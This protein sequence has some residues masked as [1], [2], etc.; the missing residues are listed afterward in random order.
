MSNK[1]G[2]EVF[3]NYDYEFAAA[4][5]LNPQKGL[6]QIM[7]ER[8][9]KWAG[10]GVKRAGNWLKGMN[11]KRKAEKAER[12]YN[13]SLNELYAVGEMQDRQ[14]LR[15]PM[16]VEGIAG[17]PNLYRSSF[18]G[19]QPEVAT[20]PQEDDEVLQ[21]AVYRA[22]KALGSLP[23]ITMHQPEQKPDDA[24]LIARLERAYGQ[25]AE[26]PDRSG[27]TRPDRSDDDKLVGTQGK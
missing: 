22:R 16:K 17:E 2:H 21:G 13:G 9:L 18:A 20:T 1:A 11:E 25:P 5:K 15:Q 4:E 3:S 27:H 12:K 23:V 7:G 26:E 8:A 19:E 14:E 6:V 10:L 24:A